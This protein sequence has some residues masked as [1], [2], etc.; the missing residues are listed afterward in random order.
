VRRCLGGGAAGQGDPSATNDGFQANWLVL[1]ANL[2]EAM[3]I[4]DAIAQFLALAGSAAGS[5]GPAS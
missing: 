3:R 1:L 2:P 5:R 4:R